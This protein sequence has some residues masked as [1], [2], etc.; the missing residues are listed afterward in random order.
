M[1]IL[2]LYPHAQ[3]L[4]AALWDPNRYETAAFSLSSGRESTEQELLSWLKSPQIACQDLQLIAASTASAELAASLGQVLDVKVCISEPSNPDE[5][6]PLAFVTGTPALSRKCSTDAFI[7]K[8]MVRQEA[9]AK[10]LDPSGE[11]FIV[12]HLD[13]VHQL[14]ALQGT[15]VVDAL[16]SLDEGPFALRQS[17]ALPFDSVLDLCME[18]G[19]REEVLE[20]LHEQGGLFG[21]LGLDNLDDLWNLSGEVADAIREALIYQI[22][23]EIGA[24]AAVL[25]G[26]VSSILLGGELVRHEPFV[27]ALRQRIGF[28]APVSVY[29]GNQGLPALL[30]D[31]HSILGQDSTQ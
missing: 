28:I 22:S 17:G 7:F 13:Q 8:F 12:A 5:C 6:S 14:G 24:L 2:A 9:Q 26:R 29:P 3:I 10:G 11:Q 27:E 30:A 31:A 4:Q 23:K 15:T 16:T 18:A 1:A 25:C 20:V 19:G 21:Y